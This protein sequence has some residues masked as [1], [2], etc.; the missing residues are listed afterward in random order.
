MFPWLTRK[1][2]SIANP[3]PFNNP[4]EAPIFDFSNTSLAPDYP[5]G[6]RYVKILDGVFTPEE[7][8]ALVR[9]AETGN[10]WKQAAIHF[11]ME[12]HQQLVD[13]RY[14]NSERILR[15]DEGVVQWLYERLKPYVH[16]LEEI[17]PESEWERVV[18]RPG[19][20]QEW[21]MIG[22]NERLSFLRYGRGHFFKEHCDGQVSLPDGR[23]G[24][25]TVQIYLGGNAEG[26][27][28]RI[29]SRDM[30]RWLDVEPKIGRALVFQQRDV[31]HSGQPVVRGTK[32]TV[33][34]DIMFR[35]S[36]H[37]TTT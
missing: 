3:A 12:E 26:G 5:A 19:G 20:Q 6:Q 8:N 28:T 18:G 37:S 13:T 4:S 9:F 22:L 23:Q 30:R 25:V 16:E 21:R 15:F 10:P 35:A 14:R 11:G 31:L 27:A 17:R 36:P 24:R 7:C 33:R 34:T 29:W 1:S 32:L 2:S